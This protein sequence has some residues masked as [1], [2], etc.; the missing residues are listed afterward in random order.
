MCIW[1][2]GREEECVCIW[3]EGREERVYNSQS[4]IVGD[5]QG[6]VLASK[7]SLLNRFNA[8]MVYVYLYVMGTAHSIMFY[9]ILNTHKTRA[10]LLSLT[11][12][13]CGPFL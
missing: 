6:G 8:R 7:V 1:G 3:A 4:A 2:E 11:R 5:N 10:K 12:Q 9:V 13:E